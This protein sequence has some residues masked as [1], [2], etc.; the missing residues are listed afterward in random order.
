MTAS[1]R[2]IAD[3]N[4]A[5][6]L[7]NVRTRFSE[8]HPWMDRPYL[9]RGEVSERMSAE[10]QIQLSSTHAGESVGEVGIETFGLKQGPARARETYERYCAAVG[11]TTFDGKPL[12]DFTELGDRQKAGWC[13][14]GG[15][16]S[17][18]NPYMPG[19]A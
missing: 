4:C 16:P 10:G 12:P 13:A 8:A 19:G 1:I 3:S 7:V 6:D 17:R 14:A 2:I 5:D 11:G 15:V 18:Y 9:K